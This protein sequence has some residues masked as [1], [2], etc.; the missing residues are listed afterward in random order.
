MNMI[1]TEVKNSQLVNY[2]NKLLF[3]KIEEFNGRQFIGI[4]KTSPFYI[5]SEEAVGI[6]NQMDRDNYIPEENYL[7]GNDEYF[8]ECLKEDTILSQL[9]NMGEMFNLNL[10]EIKLLLFLTAFE[11]DKR[12]KKIFCYLGDNLLMKYPSVDVLLYLLFDNDYLRKENIFP[13]LENK[14]VKAYPIIEILESENNTALLEKQLRIKKSVLSFILNKF[15]FDDEIS[16]FCSIHYCGQ[17]K[18]IEPGME[19][20]VDNIV[21]KRKE[22][23][24]IILFLHGEKGSGKKEYALRIA[25]ALQFNLLCVETAL[26]MQ[27]AA[28]VE[29]RIRILFLNAYLQNAIVYFDGFNAFFKNQN[30]N[31]Y[32]NYLM[33]I[34]ANYKTILITGSNENWSPEN[35][36]DSFVYISQ[37]FKNPDYKESTELWLT[38]LAGYHISDSEKIASDLANMFKFSRGE[39]ER[40][41]SLISGKVNGENSFDPKDLFRFCRESVH[42]RLL[43]YAQLI[44]TKYDLTDMIL[45]EEQV[46][47]INDFTNYWKN[48]HKVID[49]WGFRKRVSGSGVTALFNGPPGTGKTMAAGIV[50]K[51]LNLAAYR[52]DVS[53]LVSKY[54]GET[55]KNL[56]KVFDVAEGMGVLLF[57]DEADSI[58][59]KR[60]DVGDSHDKY[61]N[62]ETSYLLQRIEDYNGP[63]IL[64]SNFLRNIDEAFMRR[65]NFIIE[66]PLPDKEMSRKIW[67]VVFPE[68]VK[69]FPDVNFDFLVEKFKFSGGN[70]RNITVNS[71]FYAVEEDSDEIRMKHIIMA[72]KSELKKIGK[73]CSQADFGEYWIEG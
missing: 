42:S 60:T 32:E 69:L 54:I 7:M 22:N 61:A 20:M 39:I 4:D 66:F 30:G 37:T 25:R 21:K 12:Y 71:A 73:I 58:F 47:Q 14:L 52:I 26:F 53:Q 41:L 44:T 43:C 46:S 51:N 5:S 31:L 24:N 65:I 19:S 36:S 23:K 67:S 55:E 64:A 15:R 63:V 72:V 38:A 45:P 28:E 2:L 6:I 68:K 35:I 18:S 29:N 48:R 9:Y 57:F 50:A 33:N 40:V 27:S 13:I 34:T 3:K 56:S 11:I 1:K 59:G 16:G 70:I 62:L 10:I 8:I 49:E 17:I